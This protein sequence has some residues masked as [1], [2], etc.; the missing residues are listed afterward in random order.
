VPERASAHCRLTSG[1]SL[2]ARRCL[3][4]LTDV[5]GEV[6][7]QH[8]P[9]DPRADLHDSSTRGSCSAAGRAAGAASVLEGGSGINAQGG[10]SD[11]IDLHLTRAELLLLAGCVNEAIEAVADWEFPIR[12]G[13]TKAEARALSGKLASRIHRLPSE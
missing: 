2:C 6:C 10:R 12:L 9:L 8:C 11:Q 4:H 7:G 1:L 5:F 3:R 13:A